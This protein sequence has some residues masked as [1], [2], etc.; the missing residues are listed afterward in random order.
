MSKRSKSKRATR[1]SVR[2]ATATPLH[3]PAPDASRRKMRVVGTLGDSPIKVL[4]QPI[5]RSLVLIA[6]ERIEQTRDLIANL[7]LEY[8]PGRVWVCDCDVAVK[9]VRIST[10]LLEHLWASSLALW[11][12]YTRHLA[13]CLIDE[14]RVFEFADDPVV[15]LAMKLLSWSVR[16]TGGAWPADLPRPTYPPK[17]DSDDHVATE[18]M[19]CAVAFLFH[20]ELAHYRLAH[21][22]T[23]AGPESIE[24]ERDADREAARWVLEGADGAVH[25]K[26]MLG[27]AIGLAALVGLSIRGTGA[28]SETHPR[29]FDRLMDTLNSHTRDQHHPAWAL[30]SILMKLY[31]DHAGI[32]LPQ[33]EFAS[34][35]AL[36]DTIADVLAERSAAASRGSE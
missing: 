1:R 3:V 14:P 11:L 23:Q 35:R 17:L 25:E 16:P 26:R 20:H 31:M 32:S 4:A 34:T 36:C 9:R 24:N 6:P 13:G 2:T 22:P 30:A 21:P 12:F 18:L 28:A 29:A 7:T 33:K 15:G 8:V 5:A 27:V 10:G 19:L